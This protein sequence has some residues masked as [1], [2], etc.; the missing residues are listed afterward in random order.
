MIYAKEPPGKTSYVSVNNLIQNKTK[1]RGLPPPG[2]VFPKEGGESEDI[3]TAEV[4]DGKGP[5]STETGESES[6]GPPVG[7]VGQPGDGAE[8]EADRVAE[9]ITQSGEGAPVNHETA[10][11]IHTKPL[12]VDPRSSEIAGANK[13][14]ANERAEPENGEKSLSGKEPRIIRRKK[15]IT[16]AA[17]S[18]EDPGLGSRINGLKGKG[19][20]LP[21]GT[22]KFFETKLNQDFGQVRIHNDPQSHEIA[23]S[24]QARAFTIGEDVGFG[25]GEFAPQSGAGKKLL[26]HELT[27]VMQQ[28]EIPQ[29]RRKEKDF[30]KPRFAKVAPPDQA[31]KDKIFSLDPKLIKEFMNITGISWGDVLRVGAFGVSGLLL[32]MLVENISLARLNQRL[33]EYDLSVADLFQFI[34]AFQVNAV[35]KAEKLIFDN[36]KIVREERER[37]LRNT[38]DEKNQEGAFS[39][40]YQLLTGSYARRFNEADLLRARALGRC[41]KKH[42]GYSVGSAMGGFLPFPINLLKDLLGLFASSASEEKLVEFIAKFPPDLAE[43][44]VFILENNNPVTTAMTQ[45]IDPGS[46]YREYPEFK[47]AKEKENQAVA[48]M[49]TVD[50]SVY[51]ILADVN[52]DFRSI[53]RKFRGNPAGLQQEIMNILGDR[54]EK[55]HKTLGTLYD[56]PSKVWELV[57]LIQLTMIDENIFKEDKTGQLIWDRVEDVERA[58]TFRSIG[59]AAMGI[60][61]GIAGFFTGGATWAALAVGAGGA[62]VSGV[63]LYFELSSYQLHSNAAQ[64][65]LGGELS[66]DPGILGVTFAVI[67][68]VADVASLGAA[69]LKMVKSA[70]KAIK[71]TEKSTEVAAEAGRLYDELAKAGKVGKGVTRSE[72]IKIIQDAKAETKLLPKELA[73]FDKLIKT[74]KIEV[75]PLQRTGWMK[76]FKEDPATC[77]KILG[78]F[79]DRPEVLARLSRHVLFDGDAAKGYTTIYKVLNGEQSL[80][81]MEYLGREGSG[82]AQEIL[83]GM[84]LIRNHLGE[85]LLKRLMQEYFLKSKNLATMRR[86]LSLPSLSRM[87]AAD[88]AKISK[89]IGD[90]KSLSKIESSFRQ[91]VREAAV[92]HLYTSG[93]NWLDEFMKMGRVMDNKTS[94][95]IF[96]G[97]VRRVSKEPWGKVEGGIR[98]LEANSFPDG[99]VDIGS[100]WKIGEFKFSMGEGE[101]F[102]K[103]TDAY[104][105]LAK[106]AELMIDNIQYQGKP[107]MKIKVIFSSKEFAQKNKSILEV[108]FGRNVEIYYITKTLQE[109]RL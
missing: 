88:F 104:K 15:A 98:N 99:I 36:R 24:L 25:A 29:I 64:A 59:L 38:K 72:F 78:S 50:A 79:K 76:I 58:N 39:G 4:P 34:I 86:W 52:T 80:K 90:S 68:L 27:H 53:A 95:S 49:R 57:P 91:G 81:V 85:E 33:K 106:Y 48:R 93:E 7:K 20:P 37:Y 77:A 101:A 89:D 60:A 9:S 105:R 70:A 6:Q 18:E 21:E 55:A 65:T 26:A 11:A 51:P 87:D 41:L 74:V 35:A 32:N 62:I 47:A 92:G 10:P 43:I 66:D 22:R 96:E 102:T 14:Q 56:N 2:A 42:P 83:K 54:E 12:E 71:E 8:L 82:S 46:V 100:G 5:E 103:G 75:S 28:G 108:L 31:V 45:I 73:E 97:L 109:G 23:R 13:D 84:N 19:E 63:D 17:A 94:G 40:L 69:G 30:E 44:A 67:G 16:A 61:L 1:G 107:I 3:Q